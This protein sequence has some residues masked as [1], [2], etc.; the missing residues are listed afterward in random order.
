MALSCLYMSACASPY[1]SSESRRE[2]S[3]E[4]AATVLERTLDADSLAAA[5][6]LRQ[7]DP[8]RT[9]EL[10]ARATQI[11]PDRPDLAWLHVQACGRVPG[12]DSHAQVGRLRTLDPANGAAWLPAVAAA[13]NADDEA[14]RLSALTALA[15]TDHIDLYWTTFVVR[16]TRSVIATGELSSRDALTEMIGVLTVATIP[17]YRSVSQLCSGARLDDRASLQ[18]CR[19]VALALERGDTDITEMEGAN[20][21]QRLWPKDSPEWLAANAFRRVHEYRAAQLAHSTHS[22][23]ADNRAAD[24]FLD[25]CAHNHREQDV[26]IAELVADG[27]SP[28]PPT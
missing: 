7:R 26:W 10:L 22:A 24:E 25:L 5:A 4:K 13:E 2:R 19:A 28:V 21:A 3:I 17:A 14:M 27:K 16:L 6:L 23:F 20:I 9:L 11:A 1:E 15:R 12:C 8:A 18:D